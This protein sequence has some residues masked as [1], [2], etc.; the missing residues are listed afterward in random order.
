MKLT[1]VKAIAKKRH[2]YLKKLGRDVRLSDQYESIAW[3]AGFKDWNVY[4]AYLKDGNEYEAESPYDDAVGW[5][6]HNDESGNDNAL[7]PKIVADMVSVVLI[8]NIF[9]RKP[10]SV[11][12]DVV[13]VR[14]GLGNIANR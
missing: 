3:E 13:R 10:L 7:N 11:A 4:S 14:R 8:A 9:G 2:E 1:E 5:I 6:A 12:K